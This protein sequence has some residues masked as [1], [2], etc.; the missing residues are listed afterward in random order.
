MEELLVNSI[1]GIL[2]SLSLGYIVYGKIKDSKNVVGISNDIP[3]VTE[4]LSN[5][6]CKLSK[7]VVNGI[8]NMG[9]YP[10]SKNGRVVYVNDK[11]YDNTVEKN[12]TLVEL[13]K[14]AV[15]KQIPKRKNINQLDHSLS[16]L[17]LINISEL[18]SSSGIMV[19][20]GLLQT[21]RLTNLKIWSIVPLPN[22]QSLESVYMD[23]EHKKNRYASRYPFGLQ[24]KLPISGKRMDI[25][26]PNT[27]FMIV[28]EDIVQGLIAFN[29]TIVDNVLTIHNNTYILLSD[30]D[31][32]TIKP[33]EL[34]M[35]KP[36]SGMVFSSANITKDLLSRCQSNRISCIHS[37]TPYSRYIPTKIFLKEE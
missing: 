3:V 16:T 22:T 8:S 31:R 13:V 15:S 35:T 5:S 10:D 11:T 19:R 25:D 6:V 32:L 37:D 1:W 33:S 7:A 26:I 29:A 27:S 21:K 34:L 12:D 2:L 4:A 17:F 18:L 30:G 28:G 9:F 14:D 36:S 20:C 24:D 23:E